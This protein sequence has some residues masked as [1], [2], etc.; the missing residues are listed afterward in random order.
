MSFFLSVMQAIANGMQTP[1]SVYGFTFSFW[2][3]Y[4]W[5]LF[6]GLITWVLS[7]ILN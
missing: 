4:W 3:V 1:F 7:R 6:V 2:D 5:S